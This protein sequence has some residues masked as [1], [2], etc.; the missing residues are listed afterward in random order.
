MTV[1]EMLINKGF[2]QGICR[3]AVN[4]LQSGVADEQVCQLDIHG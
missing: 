1:R 4:M 2:Q 3:V